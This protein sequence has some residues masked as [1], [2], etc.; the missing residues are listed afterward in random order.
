MKGRCNMIVI[1]VDTHKG[2]HALSAVDEGTGRVR[3]SREIQADDA[4][5][6]AAVRWARGLDGERV[7]AIEDC[8][9]VSRRLEQA[10]LAAGERVIRVAPKMMGASRRGERERGKS[11]EIDAQA[12]ARAVVKDGVDRFPTA[13]L[14]ERAMEIRLLSDHRE[15]LVRERTRMQNRL[16]WHLL[17]LCPELEAQLPRSA[18]SDLRQLQRLDRRLRRIAPSTRLRVAR[19]ELA[20]IRALTR[21]AQ[22]LERE[23]LDLINAY[24]PRLLQEQGCGTLTAGLLI[25]RTAGAERFHSDA[26]FGRQSGTAPI[27]CSS[28]QRTNTASTAAGTASSTG[29]FTPSRS[30]APTTTPPPRN[31][32]RASGPRARRPRARCAASSATSPAAS[33]GY[34][35]SRRS[36]TSTRLRSPSR[37]QSPRAASPNKRSTAPSPGRSPW[38]VS[39]RPTPTATSEPFSGSLSTAVNHR[40]CPELPQLDVIDAR[41]SSPHHRATRSQPL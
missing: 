41:N 5:H 12:V 27:P 24:R 9:H 15:D 29:R 25:G 4:G 6:L 22:E 33:G 21:Q 26:C 18:L 38:S 8:R 14:D 32:S 30:P 3:G 17:E 2:S 11:D 35:P 7:W 1:G 34:S 28:G 10:L 36:P 40:R 19:E 16:R 13:Y 23:L 31:T 37:P 20:H 39:P